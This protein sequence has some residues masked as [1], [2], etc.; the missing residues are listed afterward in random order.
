MNSRIFRVHHLGRHRGLDPGGV[1]ADLAQD[2]AGVLAGHRRT[3]A[4]VTRRALEAGRQPRLAEPSDLPDF[5]APPMMGERL[6]RTRQW[7]G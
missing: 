1:A 7:T 2:V 3:V 5:L 4:D 6:R